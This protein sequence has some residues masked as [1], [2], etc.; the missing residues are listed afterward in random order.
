MQIQFTMLNLNFGLP[1]RSEG[2][3]T[4]PERSEGLHLTSTTCPVREW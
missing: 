4:W 1:E 3:P 2:L